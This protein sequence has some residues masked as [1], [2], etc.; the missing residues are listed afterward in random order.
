V[1]LRIW[2]GRTGTR[3]DSKVEE[4][5]YTRFVRFVGPAG[6]R[7]EENDAAHWYYDLR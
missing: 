6:P 4:G 7:V 5:R 1:R 3:R 2:W